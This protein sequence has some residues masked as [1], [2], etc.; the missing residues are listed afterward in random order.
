MIINNLVV[1]L[2]IDSFINEMN[3]IENGETST[4]EKDELIGGQH[5][6]IDRGN[7]TTSA[8][9]VARLRNDRRSDLD[10]Q[11]TLLDLLSSTPNEKDKEKNEVVPV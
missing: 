2:I 5:A 7:N 10:L 8:K 1:G 9:Y 4:L 3:E 6:L 11:K